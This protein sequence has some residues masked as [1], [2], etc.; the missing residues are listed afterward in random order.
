MISQENTENLGA[1]NPLA[2]YPGK[3]SWLYGATTDEDWTLDEPVAPGLGRRASATLRTSTLSGYSACWKDDNEHYEAFTEKICSDLA[4]V[5]DLP[6]PPGLIGFSEHGAPMFISLKPADEVRPMQLVRGDP[7]FDAKDP[8]RLHEYARL[9]PP[10]M[11]AFDLFVENWDN[12]PGNILWDRGDR[13][14]FIDYGWVFGVGHL[15]QCCW[16]K[17]GFKRCRFPSPDLPLPKFVNSA[18]LDQQR[19]LDCAQRIAN[20]PENLIQY[21]V[22]RA[23]KPYEDSLVDIFA[24]EVV[25]GLLYRRNK[26]KEWMLERLP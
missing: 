9:Y 26:V 12:H 23:A 15:S 1:A 14:F 11:A 17:E 4:Q 13:L 19:I 10:E 8:M 3:H 7:G 6:V 2:E 5:L 18:D 22:C 20:L 21:L 25:S 24:E 16:M